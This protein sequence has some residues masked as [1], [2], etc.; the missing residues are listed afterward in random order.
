MNDTMKQNEQ[1]NM[2]GCEMLVMSTSPHVHEGSSI[3]K[4]M[5]QV[6]LCL[7]PVIAASIWHFRF[8]AVLVI[9]Y[10]SAFCLI[11]EQ[12]WDM[13]LHQKSTLK[14]GS[15]LVTGLILALNLPPTAP[16]WLCMTGCFFAIIIVKQLFGGLGQN[17]FNPAAAARAALLAG[18]SGPMMTWTMR[19][20]AMLPPTVQKAAADFVTSATKH[21]AA[22][23][24]QTGAT[25]LGLAKLASGSESVMDALS[26]SEMYWRY[27]IGN[28]GGSLGETCALAILIGGLGLMFLRLI[29]WQ[30]PLGMLGSIALFT[31]IVHAFAPELTPGPV[32]HI[33]SGGVMIGAFFMATDMVTS[34]MTGWGSLFFGIMIGML[35]CIIRIWGGYPEGVSFSILFMNALVP[36]I[37]RIFR[38]HPFGWTSTRAAGVQMR[39]GEIK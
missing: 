13:A 36:L 18:F 30:V 5:M 22:A 12:L 37:D 34:P 14:D 2:P 20:P 6:V 1:K 29:K 27:F 7:L 21:A 24:F 26:T 38:P 17:P 32:F 31:G 25:P 10:C 9:F 3:S 11:F 15:A 8:H 23:D 4:I 16:W 33:L 19:A 28:T 35:T 39:R